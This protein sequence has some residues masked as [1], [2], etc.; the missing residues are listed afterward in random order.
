VEKPKNPRDWEKWIDQQIREAQE[1]GEF[2]NLPGKGKPLD[3]APN[4]YAQEQ[5]LAFKILKD[6]GYA[7]EWIELDKS[8]RGR[9][10][11]ALETLARRWAWYQT[12]SS[13]LASRSDR[14]AQAER[15]RSLA[16]WD[17][18]VADFQQAIATLNREIADLNLKVPSPRFQ[19]SK[20]NLEREIARIK[21]EST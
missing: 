14:W 3:L 9:L 1:R 17:K 18:A 8:I 4:P 10:D 16:S 7:P 19:R 2:D 6:A 5:E 15:E 12:R 21:G 13:E 20:V 11:R